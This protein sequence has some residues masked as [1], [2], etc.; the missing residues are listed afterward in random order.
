MRIGI[1]GGLDR[2][3]RELQQLARAG[4]HE[5]DTH[6]GVVAG[7]AS[8]ASLRALVTRADLVLVLTEINSHN[9]VKLARRVARVHHTPLRILRRLSP[10]HLAA[11]LD[12]LPANDTRIE[13][14]A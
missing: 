4:G 9:A 10:G 2:N 12:A 14:V 11:Y 8:A 1:I 7:K 5:L 13:H 6:T 3:A